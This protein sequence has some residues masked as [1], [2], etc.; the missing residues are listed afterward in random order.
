MADRLQDGQQL[1]I[2]D[3]LVSPN[4][5]NTLL[6]QTDGNLVLYHDSIDISTAYWATDTWWLPD[7]ER[8]A[9]ALTCSISST[10]TQGT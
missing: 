1:N 2:N 6:M 7:N 5:R 9:Y 8:P 3:K 4:G 10:S